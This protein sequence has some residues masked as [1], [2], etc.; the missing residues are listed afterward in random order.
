MDTVTPLR[1]SSVFLEPMPDGVT[2]DPSQSV[3]E[4]KGA[5]LESVEALIPQVREST[6]KT[7]FRYKR[8]YGKKVRPGRVSMAS[9]DWIIPRDPIRKHKLD[10]K[11]TR[12][13]DGPTTDGEPTLST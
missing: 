13:L 7:Q 9:R 4:A 2:P 8:D 6:A 12:P 10:P 3:A 5:F 1:L 11:V